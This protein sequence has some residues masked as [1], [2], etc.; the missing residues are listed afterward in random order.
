M[1]EWLSLFDDPSLGNS[2]LDRLAYAS[3]QIVD[4]RQSVLLAHCLTH[5]Y[6][7]LA[8]LLAILD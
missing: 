6:F 2:A 1:D 5:G 4:R 3:Y 7:G 8:L